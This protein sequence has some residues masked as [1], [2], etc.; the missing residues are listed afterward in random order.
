MTIITNTCTCEIYDED[1]DA[2]TPSETCYGCFD[3]NLSDLKFDILHPWLNALGLDAD[4]TILLLNGSHMGWLNQYGVIMARATAPSII[5]AMSI[6]G[7]YSIEFMLSDDKRE[8][9]ARRSSHD[10]PMGAWFRF[11]AVSEEAAD[12]IEEQGVALID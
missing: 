7:E 10:E 4:E 5:K 1:T 12:R 8:M 6:N 3:D 11:T 2:T 9:S